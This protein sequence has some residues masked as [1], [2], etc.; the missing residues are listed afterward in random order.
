MNV[1]LLPKADFAV[2]T[3]ADGKSHHTVSITE[4]NQ[5]AHIKNVLKCGIN[6]PIKIGQL[7][8][9]LGVARI[10]HMTD[11]TITLDKVT[12]TQ[13]PPPK[14]GV[15]VILA[16]PRP[17]VLRRLI[18]D[19]TALG[20]NDIILVNSHRSQKSYWQSP[21]L[22]RVP[23]FIQEGL[24]QAV[25]T[26]APNVYFKKRLRPFVEDDL[27]GM[28]AQFNGQSGH[29]CLFKSSQLGKALPTQMSSLV[30]RRF[31]PTAMIAHPYADNELV[32]LLVSLH[33]HDNA[34]KPY[35]LAI[36]AEGG[37]T[38]FEVA[39]FVRYGFVA[40]RHGQ[41]ILR[42]EAVVNGILG[43]FIH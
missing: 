3:S 19:M 41:R 29:Q 13:P 24:Q 15:S 31:Y 26:I 43:S 32:N 9:N 23:E 21:L 1:I 4:L 37:W 35:V 18:I 16:L 28:I 10:A 40:M 36:G 5:L 38:D 27:S 8:G 30:T 14:L 39:L 2:H 7:G 12:L 6:D 42:T 33:T 22:K 20:V 11:T 17:K 25:D 34:L